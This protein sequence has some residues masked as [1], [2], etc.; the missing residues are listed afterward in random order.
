[1]NAVTIDLTSKAGLDTVFFAKFSLDL[2]SD[3]ECC[4]HPQYSI[5]F[6]DNKRGLNATDNRRA[7]AAPSFYINLIFV[8]GVQYQAC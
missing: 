3:V 6:S 8:S 7:T 4:T 5:V 1:M 2:R